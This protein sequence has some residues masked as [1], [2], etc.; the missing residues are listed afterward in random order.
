LDLGANNGIF[1]HIAGDKG[2]QTISV[3]NDPIA[4]ERNYLE[5]LEKNKINVLPL[6][7]DLTNPSPDIGW[8]N[9]ERNSFFERTKKDTIFALA[10]IHHLAIS[11]N[12]PLGSIAEF[13]NQNC[14]YLIIEFVPK[15]DSQVKRL[16]SRRED[17]FSDY[18]QEIFEK[19]FKKYFSII[20]SQ[21]IKDS[22][23]TIYLMKN[24]KKL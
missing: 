3:D 23:R 21:K 15:E 17:I 8:N 6:L 14:N 11:N 13:F 2:I 7:L 16:L 22:E 18:N 10:L 12:L 1:S 24:I 9:R 19:E 20:S 4:V 5:C